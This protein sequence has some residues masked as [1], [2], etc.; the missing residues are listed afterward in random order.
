MAGS[1]YSYT[2]R[3]MD[4]AMVLALATKFQKWRINRLLKG[5]SP[6]QLLIYKNILHY[7][8]DVTD[9]GYDVMDYGYS[10]APLSPTYFVYVYTRIAKYRLCDDVVLSYYPNPTYSGNMT[11][12]HD[13]FTNQ[14]YSAGEKIEWSAKLYKLIK[15]YNRIVY[16]SDV[17]IAKINEENA[18]K[19]K[20]KELE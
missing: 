10:D 18:F 5:L 16:E 13:S 15:L 3:V 6:E 8:V 20:L 14:W 4:E 17:A 1:V 7:R 19:E 2:R 9:Y 12:I 11:D